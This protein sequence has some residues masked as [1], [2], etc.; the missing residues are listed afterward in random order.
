MH[1]K[2]TRI[3]KFF[4]S[5]KL[6]I[7]L[8]AIIAVLSLIGTFIPQNESPAFYM[9]KMGHA[10]YSFLL[11]TGLDNIYCSWW[12]ILFLTLLSLNLAACLVNRLPLKIRSLGTFIAHLGILVILLGAFIGIIYGEKALIKIGEQEEVSSFMARGR[13]VDLGFSIR[14]DD[15]IYTEHVDPKERL[16]VYSARDHVEE[17]IT[18]IPV[19]IGKESEIADTGSRIRILRY[20]PDFVM[21]TSTKEVSSRSGMPNNPAIEAEL[22]DKF[23]DIKTFWVFARFP[24]MHQ[25]MDPDFK[26]IYH[27]AGRRPKDFISKVTI[28]KGPKEIMRGDIRVNGPLDFGGYRFFQSTYDTEELR[29]SGLQVVKDPG[30]GV[31]YAGFLLLIAGVTAIFYVNPVI[32]RR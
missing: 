15:F 17:P 22:K 11:K 12:F 23:G 7:W 32:K 4:S 5:I 9:E 18:Q 13:R 26:F 29:W 31:V 8:L 24:D 19:E 30:V 14:L 1:I 3:W 6:A 27:W 16:L 21:D 10:G 20:L 28:L 2:K 25:R